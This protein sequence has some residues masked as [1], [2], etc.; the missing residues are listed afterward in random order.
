[1]QF[2]EEQDLVAEIKKY[3]TE[4]LPLSKMSDEELEEQVENITAQKLGNV[5]CSIEQR[6]SIVQQV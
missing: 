2:Q 5:Y 6:V 1:M 3:V 4:N